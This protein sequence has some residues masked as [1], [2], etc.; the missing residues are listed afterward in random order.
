MTG[1]ITMLI[2]SLLKVEITRPAVGNG[3]EDEDEDCKESRPLVPYHV[4]VD[5]RAGLG[6]TM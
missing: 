6:C 3:D 4:W 5:L 1:E 2:S